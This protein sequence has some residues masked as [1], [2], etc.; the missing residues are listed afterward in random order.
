MENFELYIGT[1]ILFG[2]GQIDKLSENIAL[3]GKD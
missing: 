3:Y 1:I 2:Q